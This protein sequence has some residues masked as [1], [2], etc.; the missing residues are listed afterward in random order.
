MKTK[1]IYRN[2]K[3]SGPEKPKSNRDFSRRKKCRECGSYYNTRDTEIKLKLNHKDI[4]AIEDMFFCE[5]TEEQYKK[6]KKSI[7][8]VWKQL[9]K[10]EELH[11][12]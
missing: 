12:I 11:E 1:K 5:L 7:Q 4:E 8:K 6:I 2:E 9:C 3:F 10:Q